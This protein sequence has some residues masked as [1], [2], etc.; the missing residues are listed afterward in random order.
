MFIASETNTNTDTEFY[1]SF[2]NSKTKRDTENFVEVK[3]HISPKHVFFIFFIFFRFL[4]LDFF[5]V[6]SFFWVWIVL[7]KKN[8]NKKLMTR[9]QR[10]STQFHNFLGGM[11]F[12]GGYPPKKSQKSK[13]QKKKIHELWIRVQTKE[14]LKKNI[15]SFLFFWLWLFFYFW[16][17]R[18]EERW[19]LNHYLN[20]SVLLNN[21]TC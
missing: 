5:W 4:S 18:C 1:I 7:M 10:V 2:F 3:T 15:L 13:I 20:V 12:G 14:K 21:K 6:L 9:G 17:M 16:L 19:R 8:K 11:F